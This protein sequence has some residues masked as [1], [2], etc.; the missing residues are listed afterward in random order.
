MVH[1]RGQRGQLCSSAFQLLS[2][3]VMRSVW[4]DVSEYGVVSRRTWSLWL[5]IDLVELMCHNVLVILMIIIIIIIIILITDDND[6]DWW[7]SIR[8]VLACAWVPNL[9]KYTS[10]PAVPVLTLVEPMLFPAGTILEELC[11]TTR[12]ICNMYM[13]ICPRHDGRLPRGLHP[14]TIVCNCQP[15][16]ALNQFR[17]PFC[18]TVK[19][20]RRGP[21]LCSCWSTF[22]E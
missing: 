7:R 14:A 10:A 13:S 11:V 22:V 9:V 5:V 15:T 18:A 17:S 3:A 1:D 2:S 21:I 16:P 4:W 8:V 20:C 6:N 12:S 19:D